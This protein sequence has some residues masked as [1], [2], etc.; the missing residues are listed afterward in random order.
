[1]P[2][3]RMRVRLGTCQRLSWQT[4]RHAPSELNHR[5]LRCLARTLTSTP[6]SAAR[7]AREARVPQGT[8]PSG[9]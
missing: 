9:A 6:A 4:R 1:M 3:G 7:P 8:R 2:E 5:L